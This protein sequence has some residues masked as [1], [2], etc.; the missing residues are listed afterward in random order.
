MSKGL[1][2]RGRSGLV[3]IENCVIADDEV[4]VLLNDLRT[5][6]NDND[7]FDFRTNQGT[8][9]EAIVRITRLGDSS[10]SVLLNPDSP[11]ITAAVER[12]RAFSQNTTAKNVLVVLSP[13]NTDFKADYNDNF[14]VIKGSEMLEEEFLGKRF[15]Y[16]SL[17]FFQNNP[18]MAEK[19]H[20]YCH[21]LL[22]VY[23]NSVY[24][25]AYGPTASLL[26]LYGGVGY[27]GIINADLFKEVTIIESVPQCI[28]AAKE[29]IL[30]NHAS[31]TKAILLDAKSLRKLKFPAPLIVL[32]DPPR[33]GMDEKTI[34]YINELKPDVLV[35]ISC[36]PQQLGKELKRFKSYEIKSAALF[37]LF[38][39][40]NHMESVIELVRK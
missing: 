22:G 39:Q 12:V 36:N 35:Y 27:F 15:F 2:F 24:T 29:N 11:Q 5:F 37:D 1:G 4:N 7:A 16:H 38:P 21:D 19:M 40:T 33:S 32:T 6:F 25:N 18:V 17:G 14:L 13:I 10:I 8:F 23:T 30:L 31:N 9:R 20:K 34:S 26:D 28:K 3:D